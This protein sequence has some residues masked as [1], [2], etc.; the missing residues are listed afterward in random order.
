MR[1]S[2]RP[3]SGVPCTADWVPRSS[4]KQS[5]RHVSRLRVFRI[6]PLMGAPKRLNSPLQRLRSRRESEESDAA[7]R[8]SCP[9]FER[10]PISSRCDSDS[11]RAS[12]R[13]IWSRQFPARGG[14]VHWSD[15]LLSCNLE[16]ITSEIS[17]PSV[18]WTRAQSCTLPEGGPRRRTIAKNA[19]IHAP[20]V[21][22]NYRR[23][24]CIMMDEH[25]DDQ[26]RARQEG[27]RADNQISPLKVGRSGCYTECASSR[28]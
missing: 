11:I 1:R 21:W 26:T 18:L 4:Q 19:E 13:P 8:L 23:L 10:G 24:Y 7:L 6:K 12:L 20:C 5:I 14:P 22:L 16:I 27:V 15:G 28:E 25:H 9:S 17:N 2:S 3:P